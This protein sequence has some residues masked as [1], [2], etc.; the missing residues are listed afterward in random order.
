V[1]LELKMSEEVVFDQYGE[2]KDVRSKKLY[3]SASDYEGDLA[4]TPST[5]FFGLEQC[6]A[7]FTLKSMGQVIHIC[8]KHMTLC[9]RLGHRSLCHANNVGAIGVYGTIVGKNTIDGNLASY[10]MRDQPLPS[11]RCAGA[12]TPPKCEAP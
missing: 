3:Q 1:K 4:N 6:C 12:C 5:L 8:G 11:A 7:L 10:A 2:D 9:Q